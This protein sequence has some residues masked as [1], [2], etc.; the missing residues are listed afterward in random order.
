VTINFLE[1][2]DR[3]KKKKSMAEFFKS[4]ASLF[5]SRQAYYFSF[6]FVPGLYIF[7]KAQKAVSCHVIILFVG[8]KLE[9]TYY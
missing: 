6:E 1:L 9:C 3:I 8:E 2:K 5:L 7:N 4:I